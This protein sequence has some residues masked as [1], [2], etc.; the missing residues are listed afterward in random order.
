MEKE[1]SAFRYRTSGPC[2]S[3]ARS[4]KEISVPYGHFDAIKDYV[5]GPEI[6]RDVKFLS[7]DGETMDVCK[8]LIQKMPQFSGLKTSNPDLFQV[9]VKNFHEL[10]GGTVLA[11]VNSRR[12]DVTSALKKA[13]EKRYCAGKIMPKP[14][15]LQDVILR[16][17]PM[18]KVPVAPHPDM[19]DFEAM[20]LNTAEAD[21][22]SMAISD[23][24]GMAEQKQAI[25]HNCRV[26]R[27]REF[28]K[29]YW[30]CLLP[31]VASKNRWGPAFRKNFTITGGCYR[32]QPEKKLIT[33]S[34]EAFVLIVY[35]NCDKR[36]PYTAECKKKGVK[37]K[38]N[39]PELA[40][41]WCAADAGLQK[42]GGWTNKGRK[43]F[44]NYAK[45]LHRIKKERAVIEM[46]EKFLRGLAG[47]QDLE[48]AEEAS[49]IS[50]TA[51]EEGFGGELGKA[52]FV[53]LCTD[54]WDEDL[55][56]GDEIQVDE[57]DDTYMKPKKKKQKKNESEVLAQATQQ[58][59]V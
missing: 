32:N 46:E 33:D 21:A 2:G 23:W 35:E 9:N 51:P 14:K 56:E 34:D 37:P 38:E 41:R 49:E 55:E 50:E 28:F 53:T 29:W 4:N 1:N 59:S 42:F 54:V 26:E 27:N 11:A 17:A 57:L 12:T 3:V 16:R 44:V 52:S 19:P 47:R 13:Y 10:Y 31:P 48:D 20:S 25:E 30:T 6:W 18:T 39:A 36:F 58:Q 40:T 24:N 15:E 45:M 5:K 43:R 22:V 8:L 7:T